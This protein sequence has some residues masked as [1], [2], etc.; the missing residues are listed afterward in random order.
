MRKTSILVCLLISFSFSFSF[1]QTSRLPEVDKSPMQ[2]TTLHWQG[3]C[4]WRKQLFHRENA[5]FLGLDVADLLRKD[6]KHD[7]SRDALHGR[8][9]GRA[10][11]RERKKRY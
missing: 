11:L 9:R 1:S 4:Y 6:G 10:G 7:A 5:F 8:R 3:G 2:I